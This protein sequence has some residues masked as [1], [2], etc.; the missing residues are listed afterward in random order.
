ME[1][2]EK[3]EVYRECPVCW[4]IWKEK[5]SFPDLEKQKKCSY[6]VEHPDQ[7]SLELL[8]RRFDTLHTQ[9]VH[10]YVET[11]RHLLKHLELKE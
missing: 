3:L 2:Q 6:C 1:K 10:R 11:L 8:K 4:L 9:Y 5:V 7:T